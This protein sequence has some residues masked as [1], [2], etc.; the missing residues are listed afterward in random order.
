VITTST[1]GAGRGGELTVAA[2]EALTIAGRGR[3]GNPSGLFSDTFARGEGGDVQV[4]ARHI[5]LR[6]GGT[7]AANSIGNGAAGRIRIQAGETFRGQA[8]AVTTATE[9]AG[10]GS[11]ALTAGR[12]VQ[13]TDSEVT[14]SVRGGGGDAG[15]LTLTAPSVVADHSSI[16]A[17]AFGGRGGSI[18]ITADAFLAD[19]ASVVSASS[20]LGIQGTV[21]IQAPVTSLSG[22]LAPLPQ[23]FVHVAALLPARCAAR[24]SGGHASSLVLG[25]RDGFPADPSGVLPSPLV[26]GE[27]LVADPT[28]TGAPQR[29]PFA[30]WFVL[31]AAHERGLPRLARDCAK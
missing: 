29:Q 27:R 11:I 19:P 24:L 1:F 25:G 7:I 2:T 6:D 28:L 9:E 26:L 30:A 20:E 21:D 13:L 3:H 14:T 12:L 16:I 18:Q 5:Q 22:A 31:L 23:V 17:N 8:G 10:G 15:N 4:A